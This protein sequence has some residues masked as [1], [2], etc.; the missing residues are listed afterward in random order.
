MNKIIQRS[1]WMPGTSQNKIKSDYNKNSNFFC[2][3]FSHSLVYITSAFCSNLLNHYLNT[4][5]QINNQMNNLE[6][7]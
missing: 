2:I 1:L 7:I 3:G 4:T 6:I 5:N